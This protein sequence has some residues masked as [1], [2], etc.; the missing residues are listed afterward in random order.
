MNGNMIIGEYRVV[1]DHK[2]L[3]VGDAKDIPVTNTRL[4]SNYKYKKANSEEWGEEPCFITGVTW[5]SRAE[6]MA[7]LVKKGDLLLITGRLTYRTWEDADK[8][9]HSVHEIEID[10]FRVIASPK[11]GETIVE[12]IPAEQEPARV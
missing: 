1:A 9:T 6:Q 12:E 3:M 4:V 2:T 11:S 5:R 8:K 10:S 7:T